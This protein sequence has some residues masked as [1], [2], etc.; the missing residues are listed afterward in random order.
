M[1]SVS[2]PFKPEGMGGST[3]ME[4]LA[5]DASEAAEGT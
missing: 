1:S 5:V 3:C 4:Q 2:P